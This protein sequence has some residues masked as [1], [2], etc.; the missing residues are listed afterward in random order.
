MFNSLPDVVNVSQAAKAL[1]ICDA[2]MRQLC[3][4]GKLTVA[5]AGTR[6][7][8]PRQSLVDFI[9]QGGTA[10]VQR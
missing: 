9:T 6:W 10:H 3:R 1:G 8:I 4:E 2:T 7:L 5:K